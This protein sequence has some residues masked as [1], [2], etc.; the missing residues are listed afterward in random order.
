[1][2]KDIYLNFLK[3]EKRYSAHTVRAYQ[4][5]IEQ[6]Y[7]FFCLSDTNELNELRNLDS[8]EIRSWIVHLMKTVSAR[9]VKRKLASINGFFTYLI[10]NKIVLHNPMSK[11]QAPKTKNM[12]PEFVPEKP[13]EDM[14]KLFD[15]H[16]DNFSAIRDYLLIELL[17]NTGMRQA[18]LIE[19]THA[20]VDAG[21]MQIK[22]LGKRNKERI[23]PLSDHVIKLLHEYVTAKAGQHFSC[24]NNAP[25]IITD[26]GHKLYPSFVYN[27]VN[28]YLGQVSS[29]KKR[30][31]HILR[32][33]F[34]THMLNRGADLNA[35]K[36]LL[37]HANLAA[38]QIYT[39]N[40]FEQLI[41]IYNKAHPRAGN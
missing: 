29:M 9:S 13:L 10:R 21:Q 25:V 28:Y 15:N 19:L 22:V 26:S 4:K 32:H 2:Q 35:I 12:L 11:V 18:E 34:A 27:K 30:S 20:D 6:F 36:E 40:S 7:L 41:N 31:P 5:D 14:L 8:K 37:G 3:F 17:Y 33:S 23:I 1:M 24:Q 38:T 16:E 39:H